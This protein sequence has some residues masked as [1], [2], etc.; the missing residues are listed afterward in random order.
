[1]AASELACAISG[2]TSAWFQRLCPH[3]EGERERERRVRVTGGRHRQ[4]DREKDRICENTI[5]QALRPAGPHKT[6][7]QLFLCLYLCLYSS[8]V[9]AY[10]IDVYM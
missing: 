6:G 3:R 7:L 5:A 8:C 2:R 4:R 9:C 10:N 1:M